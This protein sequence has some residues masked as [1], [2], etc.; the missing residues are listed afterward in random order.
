METR[1][2]GGSMV[3]GVSRDFPTEEEALIPYRDYGEG[4]GIAFNAD[5]FWKELFEDILGAMLLEI[6]YG[7]QRMVF[8]QM[9]L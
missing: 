7:F 5:S 9:L 1:R 3:H 4:G 6:R 8:Q 2:E